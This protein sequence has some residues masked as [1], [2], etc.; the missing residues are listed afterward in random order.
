MKIGRKLKMKNGSGSIILVLGMSFASV[1]IA[2]NSDGSIFGQIGGKE[3]VHIFNIETGASRTIESNSDGSFVFTKVPP[4]KYKVSTG[5]RTRDVLVVIGSG[6]KVTFEDVATITVTASR[7]RSP[8]D[9]SS[10]ESNTVFSQVDLQ[11]LPVSRDPSSVALL[12]PGTVG[13]DSA[14]GN[15]ASFGGASVAENGYYINGFDVT[16]IRTFT[17]YAAL[18]FDAISEQQIKTGGYGAEF[19]RSLGGVISL[20]TRRGTNTWKSGASIS[21]SPSWG[22]ASGKTVT[23]KDKDAWISPALPSYT[24]FNPKENQHENLYYSLYSG[25]PI[26]KDKLFFFGLIEGRRN[27]SD[28]FGDADSTQV[29]SRTPNGITKID[30]QISED[31]RLEFTG[32]YNKEKNSKK[33][34][35]NF[36]DEQRYDVKHNGDPRKSSTEDGGDVE[37]LKYTGYITDNLTV[38]AQFGRLF[39]LRNKVNDP[40]RVGFD[41]PVIIGPSEQPLFGCWNSSYLMIRDSKAVDDSDTRKGKRFDVEYSVGGHTI[42]AGWDGQEFMSTS[43]GSTFSG[44]VAYRYL[45]MPSNLEINGI[46]G[47]GTVGNPEYVNVQKYNRV[48]GKYLAKNDAMYL[49]DSWKVSPNLLAYIGIRS[50]SFDNRNAE[51]VS[52]VKRTN[53]LAPRL[54]ASWNVNGDASLKLYASAGRYY[55]PVSTSTNMGA[56]STLFVEDSFHNFSG[57]DPRTLAPLNLGA[58]IG[59]RI[60]TGNQVS[61]NPGTIADTQLR[62]MSQDEFI[63]GFQKAASANLVIGLK[64]VFRR[65]NDGMDDFCGKS[66]IA[67]WAMDQGYAN[68]NSASMADCILMNPGRPLNVLIDTKADGNLVEVSVPNSYLDLAKY[69]RMYKALELSFDHPFDGKWGLSGSYVYSKSE[70]NSE[71]YVQSDQSQNSAGTSQDFDYG[72]LT[73]GSYGRLPNGRTHQIKVFGNYALSDK[74]FVG[75]NLYLASGRSTSCLGFVPPTAMDYYGPDGTTNGGVGGRT[76]ISSYYCLNSEGRSVLGYRG[77]GPTMPWTKSLDLNLTYTLKLKSGRTLTL[78]ANVFNVFNRQ[79]VTLVNQFR[80]YSRQTTLD[81][82]GN[83]LNPNYGSP[84]SYMAP[85]SVNFS[86]RYQF[87]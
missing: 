16:N 5:S 9:V 8:I 79:T 3:A 83:K 43:A 24:L 67:K 13:G 80:D 77:N 25:G 58:E 54:G 17:N 31:H 52:F 51:N 87:Y 42:R 86:A 56:T 73:H 75:G 34:W 39:S 6:S 44:G 32:I 85:R 2:Q 70:G 21:W 11:S 57:K 61:P 62:P 37:I 63:F 29:K 10:T 30:W 84:S 65:V 36:S 19:G 33:T 71:G 60:V 26:I 69:K 22:S 28:T 23:N 53:L 27:S 48:S 72:S 20:S 35:S 18:P 74:L 40:S 7:M 81:E 68:F 15:L 50:E 12:A 49:E 45:S 41:C 59:N 55:I 38:S 78:Q 82:S 64:T 47:A 1:S 76:N 66:G 14:F 46:R 4:G